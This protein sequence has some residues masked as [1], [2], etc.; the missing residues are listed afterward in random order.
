MVV[1]LEGYGKDLEDGAPTAA[2]MYRLLTAI[3]DKV[4]AKKRE[5]AER[6]NFTIEGADQL[7]TMRTMDSPA[8][9]LQLDGNQAP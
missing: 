1:T 3:N 6:M 5:Q 7:K 8:G 2:V 9:G 4:Q